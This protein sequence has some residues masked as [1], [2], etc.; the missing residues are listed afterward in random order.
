MQTI[1]WVCQEPKCDNRYLLDVL[2]HASICWPIVDKGEHHSQTPLPGLSNYPVESFEYSF[3]KNP[4]RHLVW[5]AIAN[6]CIEAGFLKSSN[7]EATEINLLLLSPIYLLLAA[8]HSIHPLRRMPRSELLSSHSLLLHLKP[9]W[10]HVGVLNLLLE[11]SGN[12]CT[13]QC[14]WNLQELAPWPYGCIS[15]GSLQ[16]TNDDGIQWWISVIKLKGRGPTSCSPK[17]TKDCRPISNRRPSALMLTKADGSD[18]P[19]SLYLPSF[20]P[21]LRSK[22]HKPMSTFSGGHSPDARCFNLVYSGPLHM[23]LNSFKKFTSSRAE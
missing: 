10:P 17:N 2:G 23:Y 6:L 5:L 8:K 1:Q 15:E 22:V 19:I 7:E 13:P 4:C 12:S 16:I 11:S 18:W 9:L 21:G 3:I 14:C 20:V